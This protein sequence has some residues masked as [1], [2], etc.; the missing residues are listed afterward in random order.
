MTVLNKYSR[1]ITQDV[2]QPASQ[3]MLYGIGLTK[4]DMSKPQIGIVSTGYEGNTCNMHLNDLALETKKGTKEADLVGLVFH[5]IGVSDGIS[6]GTEGMRFS[7]PSRDIIADS[8]E[9]VVQAQWYDGILAV[10]G[11]DKNM[12]G[13]M[14]AL[15]RLNRPGL[16]VYGGSIRSGCHKGQKL[17]IVSAFEALG[18]RFNGSLNEEDYQG[19]IQNSCP[20][21]GACGGMYTAN[22]MATVIEAIGLGLP[23]GASNPAQSPE[24]QQECIDA[25]KAMRKLLEEDIKPLDILTKKAFE[26]A[27]TMIMV[28]GGSTNAVLHM[29]AIAKAAEV[30]LSLEDF[31]RISDKT[32]YLANLKP[33]GKYL[34]EDLHTI[35]GTP[36]VMKLLLD[37]GLLHGDCLTVTGKT[38][39]ENLAN[40]APVK[41]DQDVL[42][43]ISQP[44]KPQGHLQVLF[45]NLATQ[46]AVAKI[47]GKE[48]EKFEGTAKVYDGEFEA[49]KGIQDGEVK[50]GHVVVI[51]YEGPKGGPGMPEMLKPTSAI[52][53]AGLGNS[54]ALITDGRFSGGSHGFVVGHVCPEAQEGGL[55]ALLKDGDRITIDAVDNQMVA[56]LSEEEIA[57]RRAQWQA[58]ESRFTRGI[59]GKYARTVSSASEGCVTDE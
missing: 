34:M 35:G 8:I 2:T 37:E 3:A 30:D 9:T 18:Q 47:T 15:A 5:T 56:H 44:L 6:N 20:G 11:C 14:M 27:L 7:L 45:G 49:I 36:A 28:M 22:T 1:R 50:A 53:G 58:P 4:E 21:A 17:N 38:L 40:I 10:V 48:G 51:R 46:G 26:N 42:F 16:L 32:P 13:A 19:I 24:K 52:M 57:Q 39:A 55:I 31:Q 59:L 41:D 54:V 29:I 43:P 25:G 33:S 23:Y 12:P